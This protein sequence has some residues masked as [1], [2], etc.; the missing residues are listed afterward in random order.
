MKEERNIKVFFLFDVSDSMLFASVD[1]LKCEYGAEVIASLFS[2]ILWAG[3]STGL[4]MFSDE[5]VKVLPAES[6]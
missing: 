6:L 2:A 4:F 5:I 1:K 3:D